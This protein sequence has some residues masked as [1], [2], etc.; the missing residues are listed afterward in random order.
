MTFSSDLDITPACSRS[1]KFP[2]APCLSVGSGSK[3]VWLPAE[4]CRVRRGQRKLK[5][6]D[7]QTAE[8]RP[9]PLTG[10]H[11]YP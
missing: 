7:R 2:G 10:C 9:I 8:V 1:L 11:S 3:T 6:D 4:I 5:L